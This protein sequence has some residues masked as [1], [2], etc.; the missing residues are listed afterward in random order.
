MNNFKTLGLA[1][2][3]AAASAG[4][5][6]VANAQAALADLGLGD[7]AVVPYYTVQ[8]DFV[9]G[10]H[11]TNTSDS[12][13]VVKVR[14]RRAT[15]SMD[16]L[17]FN[18]IMSPSDVW[19]GFINDDEEGNISFNTSDNTCTA[20]ENSGSFTMPGIYRNGADTG[21]IEIIGMGAADPNQPIYTS[22]LHGAD[23]VPA[24]CTSTASNFFAA[25][26]T[27]SLNT[28]QD[29]TDANVYTDT[30]NVLKVSYFIRDGA[31]GVEFGNNAVH[32][33][34][35]MLDATITNQEFGIGSGDYQGFDFPDLNGGAP[36]GGGAL[37]GKFEELRTAIGGNTVINDWSAN[38]NEAGFTVGTD[39]VITLPGQYTM[40]DLATY[41]GALLAQ[42]PTLCPSDPA[43]IA[44]DNR[45]IPLTAQFTVYDREEQG[46]I[47]ASGELV[48][49]PQLPGV[50]ATT[51]LPQEV[52]VIEWGVAPVL[53]AED[54][55]TVTVPE[56]AVNG[57]ASLAVVA[58]TAKTQAICDFID[59]PNAPGSTIAD[60]TAVA[61]PTLVPM[62]G[63]VAWERS[64]AANPDANYG[65]I[66]EHSYMAP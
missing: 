15:D 8:G 56:A 65:R 52:N 13:Q 22:S 41:L 20:P 1:A 21:Y 54:V 16:A 32:I 27:D 31:A 63:F 36:F 62:V 59:D 12:T 2:A 26:V 46:I 25:S 5:A 30:L 4:Y 6:T 50:I 53:D 9:T 40:L 61:D 38:S 48:V 24:D 58:S 23:G 39:W 14:M 29:G 57:W 55:T 3:V 51:S 17:D 11:I 10:V 43:A 37:R 49:S 44:C 19:T 28:V 18:L 60:C 35:F 66:V 34:D 45:D 7:M 42:D 33:E 64:F 47:S